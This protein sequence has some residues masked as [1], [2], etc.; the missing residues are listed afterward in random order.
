MADNL[1]FSALLLVLL[2]WLGGLLYQ[3]WARH[4]SALGPTPHKPAT[5]LR[6]HAQ[7]PKPF[8]G[9]THKPPCALCEQAPAP[10]PVAPRVPPVPFP[11]SQGRPRQVDTT[12]QFCPQP[13]RTY[14]GWMGLGNIRANGY[15]SGGRWRQV[16]CLSCQQY[17]LETQG[18]P[19]HGKRVPPEVLGWVVGAVAKGL[20]IRAVARVFAVDPNTVLQWVLEGADQATA[21]SGISSITCTARRCRWMSSLPY[22]VP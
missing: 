4:R 21:C 7:E 9:L 19:L 11:S 5:P 6:E 22:S 3:R 2:L 20:G 10:A 16:Q 17:F 15:P 8:P 13:R 1:L 14:Y 12:T 18:T